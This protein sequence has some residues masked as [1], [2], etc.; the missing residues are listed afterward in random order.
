MKYNLDI[1]L[2][3]TMDTLTSIFV[4]TAFQIFGLIFLLNLQVV[5]DE[6]STTILIVGTSTTSGIPAILGLG[7]LVGLCF[8][9]EQTLTTLSLAYR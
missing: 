7:R 9:D 6:N 5:S 3:L 2:N 4:C 1:L 8:L